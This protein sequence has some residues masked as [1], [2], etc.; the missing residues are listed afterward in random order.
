MP[1]SVLDPS[2]AGHLRLP[3]KCARPAKAELRKAEE[4]WRA[5]VGRA[6][7]RAKNLTGLSL[8]EFADKVGRNERQ[9]ARWIAGDERPQFDALFAVEL[10]RQP[11]VIAFAELIGQGVDVQ[12]Q[13]TIRRPA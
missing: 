1:P 12:T 11:L 3:E 7:E 10:F 6:V 4:L 5:E 13:I 8:K 9:V 2:R